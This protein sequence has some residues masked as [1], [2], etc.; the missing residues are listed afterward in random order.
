MVEVQNVNPN[1]VTTFQDFACVMSTNI[2]CKLKSH[3]E[4]KQGQG[5]GKY[6]P[7]LATV[8]ASLHNSGQ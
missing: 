8:T 6:I 3:G 5:T 4:Y 2:I 7:L 1:S